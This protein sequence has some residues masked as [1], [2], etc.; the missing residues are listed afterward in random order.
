MMLKNKGKNMIQMFSLLRLLM[1][2]EKKLFASAMKN[3][4]PMYTLQPFKEILTLFTK[5]YFITEVCVQTT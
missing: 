4:A 1:Y 3:C 5:H 2:N